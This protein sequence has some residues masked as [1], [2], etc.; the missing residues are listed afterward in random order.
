MQLESEKCIL[1]LSPYSFN[2]PLNVNKT[3]LSQNILFRRH[4]LCQ[5]KSLAHEHFKEIYLNFI[6]KKKKGHAYQFCTCDEKGLCSTK[7][8]GLRRRDGPQPRMLCFQPLLLAARYPEAPCG[9]GRTDPFPMWE[10]QKM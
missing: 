8:H 9:N 2:K 7:T 5:L 10:L 6:V 3:W 4:I 1:P